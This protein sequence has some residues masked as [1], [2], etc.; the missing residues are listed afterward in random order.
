MTK[1]KNGFTLSEVLITLAVIGVV[2]VLTLPDLIQNYQKSVTET[3][4][5]KAYSMLTQVVEMAKIENGPVKFW[6]LGFSGNYAENT[7]LVAEK[8]IL[9]YIKGATYCDEGH[10]SDKCGK[11]VGCGRH[12]QNYELPDGTM[13]GICA[14]YAETENIALNI[15]PRKDADTFRSRFGFKLVVASGEFVPSYY[16]PK[17][18][19]EDYLTGFHIDDASYNDGAGY[20][21]SCDRD[22]AGY[23]SHTCTALLFVDGFKIKDDYPW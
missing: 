13:L 17:Y 8:Y 12:S 20:E 23:N 18:T 11:Y 4:L 15:S 16:D 2:A 21:V 6:D 10:T 5:K 19:R 14:Y 1:R 22:A 3:R 7:R 9:P